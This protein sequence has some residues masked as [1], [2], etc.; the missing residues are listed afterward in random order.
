MKK[1]KEKV[2]KLSSELEQSLLKA[3][4]LGLAPMSTLSPEELSKT[5]RAT[6][7]AAKCLLANGAA[8]PLSLSAVSFASKKI[9][10]GK[11]KE[12]I[13]YI[14]DLDKLELGEDAMAIIQTVRDKDVLVQ[15]VNEAGEQHIRSKWYYF[16]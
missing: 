2:I 14:H 1:H 8:M 16:S 10:G 3:T 4:I 12:I 7:K 11:K 15:I 9:F 5:G 13:R 6:L